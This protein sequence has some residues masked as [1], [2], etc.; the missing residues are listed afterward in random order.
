MM[1][2]ED[3]LKE[4]ANSELRRVLAYNNAFNCT[5]FSIGYSAL[6]FETVNRRSTP[7]CCGPAKILDVDETG[8]AVK[9]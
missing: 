5:D 1:A 8:A 9:Y 4:V 6:F 7:R 3:A 2:Q